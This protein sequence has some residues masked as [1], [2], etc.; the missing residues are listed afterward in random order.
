MKKQNNHKD[1]YVY[2]HNSIVDGKCFYIGIGRK[3]RVFSQGEHRNKEWKKKVWKE[4]GFTFNILV[5]GIKKDVALKIERS[6]IK[7]FGL[8]NLTNIVGEFGNSTAFQKGLVPWNKGLTGAQSCAYKKV[9]YNELIFD[10]LIDLRAYL[11][12][13]N[14]T[15]YRRIKKGTLKIIYLD[16]D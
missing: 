1:Y 14:T 15:L 2:C 8:N 11:G 5:N 3:D 7:Q 12:I 6:F 9:K 16:K 13:A 10:S 4:G